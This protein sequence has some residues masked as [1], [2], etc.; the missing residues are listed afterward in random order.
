VL[1][2]KGAKMSKSVGNVVA[3][4]D[5]IKQSGADILRLWVAASDYSD[6][7]RIGPEIIKT[8]NEI[9]RK[10]R[11][12]IRWMLGALHHKTQDSD[13]AEMPGLE[14][15]MLHKLSVLDGEIRKA[16]EAYDYK[17]VVA[18]LSQFMT[19]DLSAFYFD[20]RKD[21][22]YCEPL[23]SVTRRAS[24]TTIE[25]LFRCVTLWLA[26][27]LVFTAEEAW[28]ERYPETKAANGS[29][30]VEAFPD[31][32][33]AW[34]D[35]ALAARWD[36][37][38]DVR[39]V[40]TG[41]LELERAAKNIG[42]SLEAAPHV[43]IEDDRVMQLLREEFLDT[44]QGFA[45]IEQGFADICIT[46]ALTLNTGKAPEGAFTLPD[47]KGVGVVFA[48]AEGLKCA[49]SWRI[50]TDIG[51]DLSYPDVSLRDAKALR[52]W[53]AVHGEAL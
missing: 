25:H 1:D 5:V 6:D 52:E 39:R 8:F 20:I 28:L 43:F 27:I 9:Y 12:T 18:L 40:V 26:P 21:T 48:K 29:V 37:F 19:A 13:F 49:R 17:K 2:E 44:E 41:A 23:S 36:T 16:Y 46:S 4:Q 33:K 34:R 53:D 7:L 3:P 51:A 47:V 14:R 10:L 45:D 24:L 42:S 32:P 38:R 11:N 15:Y 50:R 35:E 22:L 31:V 30:H